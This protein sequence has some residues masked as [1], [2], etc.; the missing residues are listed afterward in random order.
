MTYRFQ[1]LFELQREHFLGDATKSH[2]WH[3]DQLDH[4]ECM[5]TDDK[6]V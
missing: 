6:D 5:L 1:P 3:V 2:D 4:E